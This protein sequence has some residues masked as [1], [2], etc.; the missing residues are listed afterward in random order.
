MHPILADRRRLQLY[1]GA[2]SLVGAMLAVLVRAVLG[3]PWREALLFGVPLGLAAVPMSLSA[4]YL[5]RAMPLARTPPGRV[6]AAAV[7]AAVAMAGLWAAA[8]RGWW[9]ALSRAGQQTGGTPVAP[10]LALVAGLG[11]L[12]YLV[13]L[14]V[15]YLVAAFEES[16]VAGRRV[17]QSEIAQ[18]DAELTALRAQIDPHF[19]FNSLNSIAGLIAAD[20]AKARLMCQLLA[21]FLRDS[22]A[23]GSSARIALGREIAMAEQYLRVEQVRFGP[24]L[25]LEVAVSEESRGVPVPPLIL[26]PLVE[27]AVRHGI[28]TCLEG[29]RIEITARRVGARAVIT[30]ANPR[31]VDG[32]RAGTGFGLG[33]VRRRLSASF[34]EVAALVLEPAAGSYRATVTV[35]IEGEPHG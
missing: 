13:G 35:P 14:T 12:A 3:V 21:D 30:V 22:L 26:Q 31:D 5:C 20:P 8:G 11:V 9:L 6:A 1:L 17:L 33:I 28:A 19:L 18:R 16:T 10:L 25:T 27:N 7:G 2:W 32:G 4:W 34:G 23:L 15:Q 29:G 24:R